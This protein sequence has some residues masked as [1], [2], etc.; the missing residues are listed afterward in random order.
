MPFLSFALC[1]GSWRNLF[2][3]YPFIARQLDSFLSPYFPNS[4]FHYQL[5]FHSSFRSLMEYWS[6]GPFL[7]RSSRVFCR[8]ET[9]AFGHAWRTVTERNTRMFDKKCSSPGP[10]GGLCICLRASDLIGISLQ[11]F[12]YKMRCGRKRWWELNMDDGAVGL[13]LRRSGIREMLKKEERLGVWDSNWV[14]NLKVQDSN[15][16]YWT[17]WWMLYHGW[18]TSQMCSMESILLSSCLEWRAL[19]RELEEEAALA[20]AGV[21]RF[22]EFQMIIMSFVNVSIILWYQDPILDMGFRDS[23]L[24]FLESSTGIEIWLC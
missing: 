14:E 2:V 17:T 4:I 24:H 6:I 21:S 23:T 3:A 13:R 12:W 22:F 11:W 18:K 1:V 19:P 10:I 8:L 5:T 20:I 15:E 16:I 9:A 7:L